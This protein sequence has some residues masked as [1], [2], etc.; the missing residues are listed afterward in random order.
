MQLVKSTMP[1]IS[2]KGRH[3]RQELNLMTVRWHVAYSLSYRFM[4]W[5]DNCVSKRETVQLVVK[6]ATEPLRCMAYC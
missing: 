1:A 6:F 3:F 5:Q 4:H 2:T